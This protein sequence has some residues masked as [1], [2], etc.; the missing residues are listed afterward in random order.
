MLRV[1]QGA[2]DDDTGLGPWHAGR[3]D[4]RSWRLLFRR[5]GMDPRRIYLFTSCKM[6]IISFYLKSPFDANYVNFSSVID[7]N[8]N[9]CTRSW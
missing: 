9:N 6:P 7:T 2:P 4:L 3:G 1:F 8:V 5:S